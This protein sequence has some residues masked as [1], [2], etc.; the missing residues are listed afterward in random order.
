MWETPGKCL[1]PYRKCGKHLGSMGNSWVVWEA[2]GKYGKPPGSV[3]SPQEVIE[4]PG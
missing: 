3:G 2:L 1:K 4:N